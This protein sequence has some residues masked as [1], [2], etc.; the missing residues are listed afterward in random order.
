MTAPWWWRRGESPK[1][2]TDSVFTRIIVCSHR[3][4]VKSH[5]KYWYESEMM[6]W[7]RSRDWETR[8]SYWI[9]RSLGGNYKEYRIVRRDVSE[10]PIVILSVKDSSETS[11]FFRNTR[12]YNPEDRAFLEWHRSLRPLQCCHLLAKIQ[13]YR[14]EWKGVW[15]E[16]IEVASNI[17]HFRR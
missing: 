16:R 6:V 8:D 5:M 13:Y 12:C 11:D 14:M 15:K 4:R 9:Q 2:Q 3:E 1:R 10:E 7:T 17:V